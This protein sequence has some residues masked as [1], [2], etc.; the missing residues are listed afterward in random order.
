M[1]TDIICK[2]MQRGPAKRAPLKTT[3]ASWA[4]S[5]NIIIIIIIIIKRF[6]LQLLHIK[7]EW[8]VKE[9]NGC[10]FKI[11]CAA[12]CFPSR[13]FL[14]G[15]WKDNYVNNSAN[16]LRNKTKNK[17]KTLDFFS[18]QSTC[19][20]WCEQFGSWNWQSQ[21]QSKSIGA[22]KKKFQGERLMGQ[23]RGG[24]GERRGKI[25]LQTPPPCLRLLP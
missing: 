13:L 11:C 15:P 7:G 5:I 1:N 20:L 23:K 4:P 9:N 19:I 25:F 18:P 12:N 17:M 10:T 24:E 8:N 14:Q 16:T 6:Y 3:L 2:E 22:S 21:S